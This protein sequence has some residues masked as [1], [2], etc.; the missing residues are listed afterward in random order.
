MCLVITIQQLKKFK[1]VSVQTA[2]LPYES[3][4]KWKLETVTTWK[5]NA[6]QDIHITYPSFRN[7]ELEC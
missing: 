4:A 1:T 6:V 3:I 2:P 5:N 7:A